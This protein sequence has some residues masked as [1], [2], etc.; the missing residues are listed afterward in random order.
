MLSFVA[1]DH[2]YVCSFV[3]VRTS[4]Y[5][6]AYREPVTSKQDLEVPLPEDDER[7]YLPIKPLD[8]SHSFTF[9]HDPVLLKFTNRLM[10][11]SR[12]QL[13]RKIMRD[14][15]E[16]IK[17]RQVKQYLTAKTDEER[18]KIECNPFVIFRKA[19]DNCCPVVQLLPASRGGIVYQGRIVKRKEELHKQCE[20]NKAYAHYRWK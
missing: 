19:I 14:C 10:V 20:A 8:H 5:G 15:F 2:Q 17:R 9:F 3:C 13:A 4:I 11:G 1:Q 16:L 12:K 6:P 7:K 18:A